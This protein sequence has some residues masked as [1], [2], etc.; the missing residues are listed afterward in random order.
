VKNFLLGVSLAIV[1]LLGGAYFYLRFGFVDPRAS[2]QPSRFEVDLAMT[3][4]DASVARRAPR[5]QN[6]VVADVENLGA[7]LPIYETHCAVC[8]GD[9]ANPRSAV[10]LT[11]YPPAPQFL[12][13]APDM[14][15]NQNFYIID[16]GVRWT[17]MPGWNK[18]LSE[19]DIWKLTSFLA[20]IQHLPPAVEQEWRP[21]VS[22]KSSTPTVKEQ[23]AN[24]HE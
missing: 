23:G 3:F 1:V 12:E 6:P 10:G 11:L 2:Q 19:S 20:H 16:N 24:R 4:L 5:R 14:P 7:G 9:R 17:G 8:H 18:V 21:A 13:D 15:E 22:T